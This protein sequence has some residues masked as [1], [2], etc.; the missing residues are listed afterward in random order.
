MEIKDVFIS[1]VVVGVCSIAIFS[2]LAGLNE[3]YGNDAGSTFNNTLGHTGLFSN[4]S[5]LSTQVGNNTFYESG[6]APTTQ[7]EGL[8]QKAK[9]TISLIGDLFGLVP[10][11][12]KD[13]GVIVGIPSQYLDLATYA[14]IFVFGLTIIYITFLG[15]RNLV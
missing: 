11:L 14:F 4:I 8:I 2:W 10:S 13:A 9:S 15:V 1:L 5:S 12:I 3:A 6:S 7:D